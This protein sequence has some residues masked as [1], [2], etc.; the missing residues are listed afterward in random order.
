MTVPHPDAEP[1][2]DLADLLRVFY[3]EGSQSEL[4][5]FKPVDDLPLPAPYEQLLNHDAHMTVT[6]EAFHQ[7][8]VDVTVLRYV[9]D[10][11]WYSREIVLRSRETGRVVQYGIVRLHYRSLDPEV[12]RE[13][14]GRRKPLGRVLIEHDVL[15]R[16][17]LVA[18][19]RVKLARG[20]AEQLE[21]DPGAETYGRTARIFCDGHPAIELLE[22]VAPVA[23]STFD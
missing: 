4:A 11:Q 1:A 3:S 18:L 23:A 14:E 17:E 15:R 7:S 10:E 8:P 20:L 22:V 6:V 19:W 21:V 2:V 13:I 5:S 9:Q 16:V 12:W